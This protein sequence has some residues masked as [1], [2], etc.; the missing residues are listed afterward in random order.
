NREL[1]VGEHFDDHLRE[2]EFERLKRGAAGERPADSLAATARVDDQ[3]DLPDM[4]RPSVQRHNRDVAEDAVVFDRQPTQRT[5]LRPARDDRGVVD[6]L[7][8]ERPVTLRDSSQELLERVVVGR[9]ERSNLHQRLLR[10]V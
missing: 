3:S 1:L 6:R 4:A 10:S 2:P 7:L 5:R 8:E 9:L